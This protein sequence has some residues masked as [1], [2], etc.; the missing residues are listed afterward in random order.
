V[1]RAYAIQMGKEVRIMVDAAKIPDEQAV[2]LSREIAK[3]IEDSLT[4]PGQIRVS[5]IRETRA[6]DYAR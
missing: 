6:T 4:Y 1:E 5:V 3:R 2:V